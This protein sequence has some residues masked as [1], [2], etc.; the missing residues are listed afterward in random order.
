MRA[1]YNELDLNLMLELVR[2]ELKDYGS[3]RKLEEQ[4][5]AIMREL[6]KRTLQTEK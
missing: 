4:E 2:A 1:E 6:L 5:K 3:N